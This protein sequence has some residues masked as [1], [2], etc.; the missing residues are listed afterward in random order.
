MATIF[1]RMLEDAGMPTTAEAMQAK[2]D[3]LNEAHGGR[4][5]NN[6]K[7]SPFWRL[8]SAIVTEPCKELAALLCDHALPN[9]FLH[10]ASGAW[11][12]VY[13]WGVDLTRKAAAAA[14]GAVTF[15]RTG[16]AGALTIPAGTV[17]QSPALSGAVYSLATLAD[18]TAADGQL[19]VRA[20]AQATTT[21]SAANLGPG[22]YSVL[23]TPVP[24]VASVVNG[25][26]WLTIPG[27]DEETDEELRLRCRVQFSAVGQYHHDAAYRADISTFA[28]IRSDYLYFE[29]GAPRG[30]GS[31]NCYI[32][33]ETG[34]PSQEFVDSINAYVRDAGHHGHGDD[35]ACYP[36]PRSSVDLAVTVYPVEHLTDE[37]REALR[38]GVADRVRCAFRDNEDFEM[39]KI[40]PY[41]RFSFSR[42]DKELHD[43]L[44][45]L[46]SVAFDREDIVTA[47]DLPALGELTVTLGDA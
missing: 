3:A 7:W 20:A 2:W 27:A 38:Q 26:D 41:A 25:D 12:D 28:G 43:A 11:L 39:T 10:Y 18:V 34:S 1:E 29:H 14:Q 19:T 8:I 21:G 32:M 37:E 9:I 17:V 5:S 16:A 44:G 36:M 45:E 6:S 35:M 22:Y 4:I 13:A 40:W 23:P 47:M 24:G 30:P 42:L 31:A 46:Q 15:T 33:L